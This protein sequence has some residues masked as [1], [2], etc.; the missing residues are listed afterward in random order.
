[1]RRKSSAK[2]TPVDQS[3]V[4]S[5]L[6]AALAM[7]DK[8]R[9]IS[10][11]Y[12][13]NKIVIA[14]TAA[15]KKEY[16]NND[17]VVVKA[18]PLKQE[19]RMYRVYTVVETV[20]NPDAEMTVEEARKHVP[21][22]QLGETFE[23]EI[24]PMAFGRMAASAAKQVIIQGIREAENGMIAKEYE[25]KQESMV[26]AVV[27][28]V[29]PT[30]SNA[31]VAIDKNE[32]I[33]FRNEQIPS[34]NL[35]PGDRIKVFV[36][37]SRRGGRGQAVVL[38]RRHPDLIRRLI[39]LE[40]PEI[41]DGTVEIRAIAR[42]AGSRSKVAVWT[43]SENVDPIGACIGP[44]GARKNAVTDELNGE[45][46]DIVPYSDDKLEFIRAALA[47]ATVDSVYQLTEGDKAYRA[48][49]AD[50]QL[51]LAIG[52]EGQNARLA[53]KLTDARIDI[54]SRRTLLDLN[55]GAAETDEPEEE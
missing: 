34:E 50:D 29:D 25:D 49:V 30:T 6:F 38:S 20:L 18:D 44:K 2:Q 10:Q 33:L 5:E 53:A 16:S 43:N 31:T 3:I 42:E 1:M 19:I 48:I 4:S 22:I 36:T 7:L 55:Q 9:G 51:S 35:Q 14:L 23:V 11:E 28:R 26:T 15:Y 52:K 27:V 13:L 12:M 21:L 8:E 46:I 40:V 47:P 24:K 17:N 54:K 41:K 39:E 37:E 45:K 32:L